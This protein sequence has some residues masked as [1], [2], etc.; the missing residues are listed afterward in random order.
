MKTRFSHLAALA[1]TMALLGVAVPAALSQ[2]ID[3]ERLGSTSVGPNRAIQPM[4]LT[5]NQMGCR[6]LAIDG[7]MYIQSA[8]TVYSEAIDVVYPDQ[9]MQAI[10]IVGQWVKISEPISGYIF[11][12]YISLCDPVQR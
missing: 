11:S 4:P 1:G 12:R 2:G 6:E 10:A 9:Q 8:P 3:L 5:G 7:A